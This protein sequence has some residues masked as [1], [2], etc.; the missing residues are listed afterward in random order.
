MIQ[1]TNND[2]DSICKW[3]WGEIKPIIETWIKKHTQEINDYCKL[4]NID[5]IDSLISKMLKV[6]F[7]IEKFGPNMSV[8]KPITVFLCR[9]DQFN[10][11]A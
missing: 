7:D 1:I 3:Y 10:N 9:T 5:D 4:N 6:G 8:I 2:I 11:R